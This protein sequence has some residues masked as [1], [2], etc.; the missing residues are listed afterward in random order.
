MKRINENTKVT[1][2]MGQN[3]QLIK[4]AKVTPTTKESDLIVANLWT[5]K[6]LRDI[7]SYD[8]C[9]IYR[10]DGPIPESQNIFYI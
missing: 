5:K 1:L 7:G 4:E 9:G 8:E 10:I 3:R 6:V 2:T